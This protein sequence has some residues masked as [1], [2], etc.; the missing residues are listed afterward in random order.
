M[1]DC[2]LVIPC[3][4][5]SG[6]VPLF[7]QELCAEISRS[8]LSV[9]I[10]LVDDGSG[11]VERRKLEEVVGEVRA[12]Y[13][14]VKDVLALGCNRGKGG[15]IRFGWAK[16]PGDCSFLG[17]V[18]ADGSVSAKETLRVFASAREAGRGLVMAS[19]GVKGARVERSILRKLIARGFARMVCVVYGLKIADTQCG[20][21]FVGT[22]WFREYADTF[23]EDGF[24]LDL[25]LILKAQASSYPILEVGIAWREVAGSK[26]GLDSV[27]TLGKAVL[28]KRIGRSS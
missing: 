27:I 26:V 23:V 12:T 8:D 7:L 28:L 20:C 22:E 21:K 24:G 25:E 3:F 19:R 4:H 9:Q 1:I 6:R 16:A 15:A 10:Q 18:D 2:F 14:F 17:F 13:P 5:E 11:E